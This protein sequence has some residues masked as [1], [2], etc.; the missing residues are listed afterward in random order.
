MSLN[1]PPPDCMDCP[2]GVVNDCPLLIPV[3]PES[4]GVDEDCPLLDSGKM[5][6]EEDTAK[7]LGTPSSDSDVEKD[8]EEPEVE[9]VVHR[10][11]NGQ[12]EDGPSNGGTGVVT[13]S[14][15]K[16]LSREVL[17]QE[18]ELQAANSLSNSVESS[19]VRVTITDLDG[20]EGQS[21]NF[22]TSALKRCKSVV[23]QPY[24]RLLTFVSWRPFGKE[25]ITPQRLGWDL[26]NFIYPVTV[27]LLLLYTYVYE[28]VSCQWKLNVRTDTRVKN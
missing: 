20:W 19:A 24:F 13:S 6:S 8:L 27:V 10:P 15:I 12:M 23:L 3:C 1:Y 9:F 21:L 14:P 5:T 26:L 11:L 2:P 22:T 25:S 18:N 16:Y 4:L 28:V 7:G 17:L